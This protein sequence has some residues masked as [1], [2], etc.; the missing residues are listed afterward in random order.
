MRFLEFLNESYKKRIT[1][2][3]AIELIKDNVHND[4]KKPLYRGMSDG[5][6]C[7]IIDSTYVGRKSANT[8]NYYTL[9]LDQIL[10]TTKFPLRSKSIICSKAKHIAE[11]Y[12]DAL[13]VIFPMKGVKIAAVNE[14]DIWHTTF[15]ADHY[16]GRMLDLNGFMK[17]MGISDDSFNSIVED[18]NKMFE[19]DDK[20]NSEFPYML[21]KKAIDD[22]KDVK[23]SL[24]KL[25]KTVVDKFT[26]HDSS[27]EISGMSECWVEGK[28]I[29]IKYEVF[30][31]A[32]YKMKD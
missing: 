1:V 3:D 13:Y 17:D 21:L 26:L 19:N 11:D 9:I 14:V 20:Y 23:T 30:L 27:S 7:M 31:N 22:T 25:Y 10:K 24:L 16:D 4:L 12:G 15:K 8:K 6:D 18:L 32:L 5:A 29:A 28:C 2:D